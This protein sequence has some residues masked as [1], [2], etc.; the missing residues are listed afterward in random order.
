MREIG[1]APRLMWMDAV[2]DDGHCIA[3]YEIGGLWGSVAKSNYTTLRSREPIYSY[4]AL[5]L[6]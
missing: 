2:E 6:S 3:L 5:G 4:D 1:Y